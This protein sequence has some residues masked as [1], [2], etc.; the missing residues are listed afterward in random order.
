MSFF[1]FSK[2]QS[3]LRPSSLPINKN[4]IFVFATSNYTDIE[5]P[6]SIIRCNLVC[7][8][9]FL[10][11][12]FFFICGETFS[13]GDFARKQSKQGRRMALTIYHCSGSIFPHFR[14]LSP[15]SNNFL[16]FFLF[17]VKK[18]HYPTYTFG[19]NRPYSKGCILGYPPYYVVK[20]E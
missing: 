5:Q 2:K 8:N 12:S 9:C 11:M 3:P 19:W 6:A 15:R 20:G 10:T 14:R 1:F 16:H 17:F 7:V 13:H 4:G 18:V